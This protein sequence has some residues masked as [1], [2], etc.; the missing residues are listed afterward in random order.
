MSSD[1]RVRRFQALDHLFGLDVGAP[2]V[3]LPAVLYHYTTWSAAESIL[4][5]RQVWA[6]AYDCTNDEAEI[7][8]ADVVILDV[9]NELRK[10]ATR[11]AADAL[12]TFIATYGNEHV[13]K[14]VPVFVF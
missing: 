12:D 9:A 14:V 13:T 11:L 6:T 2:E 1:A 10:T 7:T 5:S 8:S 3:P 4:A